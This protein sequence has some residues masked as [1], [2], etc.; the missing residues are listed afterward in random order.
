MNY[1]SVILTIFTTLAVNNP[2]AS[3]K[4]LADESVIAYKILMKDRPADEVAEPWPFI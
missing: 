3:A 1:E 4:E 2:T